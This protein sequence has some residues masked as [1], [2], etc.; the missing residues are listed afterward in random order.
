MFLREVFIH[1]NGGSLFW[2][3][4][5]VNWVRNASMLRDI[6][7]DQF[8]VGADSQHATNIMSMST[9]VHTATITIA[10]KLAP[11]CSATAAEDLTV[12]TGELSR[13]HVRLAVEQTSINCT[14]ICRGAMDLERLGE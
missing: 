6:V 11:N 1:P 2:F 7:P 4:V 3:H 8:L 14:T 5:L 10:S 9:D 13:F 12:H